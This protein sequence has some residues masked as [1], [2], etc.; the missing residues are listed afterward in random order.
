MLARNPY[1]FCS[2]RQLRQ[3]LNYMFLR[4]RTVF[5]AHFVLAVMASRRGIGQV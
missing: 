1:G 5:Q 4:R 3:L 2:R